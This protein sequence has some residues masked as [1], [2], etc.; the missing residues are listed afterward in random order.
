MKSHHFLLI[1]LLAL[2]TSVTHAQIPH[3]AGA[4]HA[5]VVRQS[6]L[7]ARVPNINAPSVKVWTIRKHGTAR[8]NMVEFSGRSRLHMHPDAD[9]TLL[10]MQGAVWVRAGTEDNKLVAG[11]YISI[12]PNLP[13]TYWV[14]PGNKALLFSF[15]SPAYDESKT[16]FL[17]K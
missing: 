12:P 2:C 3:D 6:E 4:G 17:E 13:H 7:M 16:V 14:E 8:T 15:D 10:V 11:D 9:H 1:L 5:L